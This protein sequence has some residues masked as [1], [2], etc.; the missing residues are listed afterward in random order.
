[1]LNALAQ[2]GVCRLGCERA[3]VSLIDNRNQYVVAEVTKSIS[4]YNTDHHPD[5]NGLCMGVS[6]LDL[7]SGICAGAMPCFIG[8]DGRHNV[9]TPNMV[10][11]PQAFVVNDF[12]LEPHYMGKPYV[13]ASPHMRFYAGVPIRSSAGHV[14]GAYAVIDSK[15]HKGLDEQGL[16]V[17]AEI[18]TSIMRHLELLKVQ[19]SHDSALSF[20]GSL[21]S[22]VQ[23]SNTSA[24]TPGVKPHVERRSST[25][26]N[27]RSDGNESHGPFQ[28]HRVAA[29]Q[30]PSMA[31][32]DDTESRKKRRNFEPSPQRSKTPRTPNGVKAPL[33]EATNGASASSAQ[34]HEPPRGSAPVA[35]FG[36]YG[37]LLARAADSIRVAMRMDEV[38]FVDAPSPTS[39]NAEGSITAKAGAPVTAQTLRPSSATQVETAGPQAA[40]LNHTL[41]SK[42]SR[43]STTIEPS[44]ARG[45][46]EYCISQVLHN[47][48]L[49][50]SP[51]GDF[52]NFTTKWAEEVSAFESN[53]EYNEANG[54]S[55]DRSD[56]VEKESLG[57][58]ETSLNDSLQSA[59]PAAQSLMFLPLFGSENGDCPFSIV[60]WSSEDRRI[61]QPEDFAYLGLFGVAIQAEFARII[62]AIQNRAKSDFI[63][64]ISHEVRS[65]LHGILG[66]AELLLECEIEQ[67]QRQMA[68]MIEK[69]G[70]SL[71]STMEHM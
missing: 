59:F 36:Q 43:Y 52:F 56:L 69:C 47:E 68:E 8:P 17:L 31:S 30:N 6:A 38:L 29:R 18:A 53:G 39:P 65:P 44:R 45:N 70:R 15:P 24:G 61:L 46:G 10:A 13:V 25:V 7:V 67:E 3:F 26:G 33:N 14:I 28:K 32:H 42:P 11:S 20:L 41:G 66:N 9:K 50:Q 23:G 60:A 40:G 37:S 34:Q 48:L 49:S 16:L 62:S 54:T 63:S 27:E 21:K 2:L 4:L 57:N 5:D 64:S 22:F 1:V 55:L 71:L 51:R 58:N 35:A 12:T 19:T